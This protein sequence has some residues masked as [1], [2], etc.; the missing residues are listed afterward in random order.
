MYDQNDLTDHC[1]SPDNYT[2][3]C[4]GELFFHVLFICTLS[5]G[6]FGA[7][8]LVRVEFK[9]G[10]GESSH[11]GYPTVGRAFRRSL[12]RLAFEIAAL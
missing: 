8:I 4:Q 10:T 9:R 6:R 11:V 5:D 12:E 7:G 1:P 2:T 3:C